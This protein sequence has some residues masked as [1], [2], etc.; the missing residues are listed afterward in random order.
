MRESG[1]GRGT[2][3]P[4]GDART[5]APYAVGDVVYSDA[6][7]GTVVSVDPEHR[8]ISVVWDDAK[9]KYGPITYPDDNDYLRRRFPW[10]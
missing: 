6:S 10:E 3:F 8:T 7:R 5:A 1:D 9:D 2:V 4:W